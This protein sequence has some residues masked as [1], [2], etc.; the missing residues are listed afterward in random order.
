MW[1]SA[2]G[3]QTF[4][5]LLNYTPVA[6]DLPSK[7]VPRCSL[8]ALILVEAASEPRKVP[9]K[10]HIGSIEFCCAVQPPSHRTQVPPQ[11]EWFVIRHHARIR[12]P[13]SEATFFAVWIQCSLNNGSSK[14]FSPRSTRTC[15][16]K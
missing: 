12:R 13:K 2:Q 10:A 3:S 15:T 1:T 5:P 16:W 4:V 7:T 8:N 9:L 6:L 14:I 11:E